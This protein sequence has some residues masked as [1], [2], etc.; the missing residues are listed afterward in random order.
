MGKSLFEQYLSQINSSIINEETPEEKEE[1][2]ETPEETQPEKEVRP[3]NDDKKEDIIISWLKS[4]NAKFRPLATFKIIVEKNENGEE[5][6]FLGVKPKEE[7]MERY[8]YN[9]SNVKKLTKDVYEDIIK[10]ADER[11]KSKVPVSEDIKIRAKKGWKK[12]S[13]TKAIT[14]YRTEDNKKI[15]EVITEHQRGSF[16]GNVEILRYGIALFD[17][18]SFTYQIL[19][20]NIKTPIEVG[21]KLKEYMNS[22]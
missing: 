21:D 13:K 5:E 4:F 9:L 6:T 20:D 15:L 11:I 12:K 22:I 17:E 3:E 10:L 16:K 2:R 8:F 14:E 1:V 18:E 7:P 19:E